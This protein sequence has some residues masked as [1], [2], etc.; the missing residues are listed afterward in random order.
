MSRSG[1]AL[2]DLA[3]V[4]FFLRSREFSRPCLF[5]DTQLYVDLRSHRR[6]PAGGFSVFGL[7]SRPGIPAF[8]VSAYTSRRIAFFVM[9]GSKVGCFEA[10]LNGLLMPYL[11]VR[12][13]VP[14]RPTLSKRNG[15]AARTGG[16]A[17]LI[18]SHSSHDYGDV[19]TRA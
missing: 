5:E 7:Q 18:Q 13:A 17:R 14:I 3:H 1:I 12:Q 9:Y 15:I 8:D 10:G 16:I 6:C 19:V 4:I 11:V 2:N